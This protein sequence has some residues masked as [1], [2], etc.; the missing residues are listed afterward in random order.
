M[1]Y[2]DTVMHTYVRHW[3]VKGYVKVPITHHK[4]MAAFSWSRK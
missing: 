3:L 4:S 2:G 1:A